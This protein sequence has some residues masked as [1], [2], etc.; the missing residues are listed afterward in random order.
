MPVMESIATSINETVQLASLDGLENVYLAKVDSSH[1]LRLQSEVGRRLY[2][3]ATG[4]G[5]VLLAHLAYDDLIGRLATT[6]LPHFTSNTVTDPERLL[7]ELARVRERGFA[8]DAEEYTPGLCCVAVP[9][10]HSSGRVIAA[11]SFSLPLTRA[12][13]GL[14]STA[15]CLLAE[16]SL[17][18]TQRLG[19]RVDDPRLV[20]LLEASTARDMLAPLVNHLIQK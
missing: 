10:H 6:T 7:E 16:G 9:V 18:I 4:L 2:S 8:I 17:R 15:L 3:H 1:P 19:G 5:K 11:I 20:K 14:L 13:M 12:D